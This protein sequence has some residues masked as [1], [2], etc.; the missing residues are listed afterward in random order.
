MSWLA[1]I[2]FA[3]IFCA[4]F[5]PDNIEVRPGLRTTRQKRAHFCGSC[6]VAEM[7]CSACDMTLH[8][9]DSTSLSYL[10]H[11][12]GC[13]LSEQKVIWVP[14]VTWHLWGPWL[15]GLDQRFSYSQFCP[16]EGHPTP[17]LLLL[18]ASPEASELGQPFL[19]QPPD[20]TAP[21]LWVCRRPGA[22]C[23]RLQQLRAV[24]VAPW[25]IA[26]V[27]EIT[28]PQGECLKLL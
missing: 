2:K 14:W 5:S 3:H 16:G 11:R 26:A 28:R 4:F 15:L 27:G 8:W 17:M 13:V 7:V 19:R 6:P 9:H 22:L 21:E 12:Q 25:A 24:V 18:W 10:D 20:G 1:V 23:A